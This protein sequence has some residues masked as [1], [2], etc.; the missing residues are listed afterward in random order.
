MVLDDAEDLDAVAAHVVNGAFWNMGQ[1][2]SA[3]SRLIVQRGIR[4]RLLEKVRSTLTGIGA[5]ELLCGR[6]SPVTAFFAAEAEPSR[7]PPHP[8]DTIGANAYMRWKEWQAR[9]E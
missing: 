7:L 3:G 9:Q 4:D 2:C 5:A 8:F 6:T 1:N